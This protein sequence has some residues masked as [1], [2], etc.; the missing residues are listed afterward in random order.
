[1]S[2][3]FK[4]F[5]KEISLF[6]GALLAISIG[7]A[8]NYS[9]KNS[10][11]AILTDA[12]P[13]APSAETSAQNITK[14]LVVETP[15]EKIL[16]ETLDLPKE[17]V[18]VKKIVH[19]G[20][21][22]RLGYTSL[23]AEFKYKDLAHSGT[24]PEWL[25]GSFVVVGPGKF[26]IQSSK[27]RTWLDGFAMIHRFSFKEGR[28]SYA[29][30]FLETTYYN[31]SI[32]QGKMSD[33][34]SAGDP[35]ASYF[36]KL[37]AAMSDSKSRPVYDNTNINIIC[38]NHSWMALT[39]TPG[40]TVVDRHSLKTKGKQTFNDS[41]SPHVSCAYPYIDPKT[42]QL[43]N[44]MTTYARSKSQ[45][46]IYTVDPKKNERK[47]LTTLTTSY[48][49]YMH[50]FSV[51][52]HYIILAEFPLVVNPYD[53]AMSGKPYIEN[54]QWK[55]KQGTKFTILNRF[56]GTIADTFT[57]D[58][59]FSLNHINAFE[60]DNSIIID[61]VAHKDA[62]IVKS[63]YL[64]D[65]FKNKNHP[66]FHGTLKRISINLKNNTIQ[67][68]QLNPIPLEM[69]RINN[70]YKTKPYTY[71]YALSSATG[72]SAYDRLIKI[73]LQNNSVIEWHEDYCY[74]SEPTFVARPD[75]TA[76]DDGVILSVVLDTAT[77]H[78]F[79]LIL[80]AHTME[81]VARV[82]LS[83]HIPFSVH[84]NFFAKPA[85]LKEQFN[86]HFKS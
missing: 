28:V 35:N 2:H 8:I 45:Y 70:D 59:F 13:L 73:N 5:S 49:S 40:I 74:P 76:E 3:F 41:L 84:G 78:S 61:L 37:A 46:T 34:A 14:P 19:S 83:H 17:T 22:H 7:L 36:S 52:P 63:Y 68:T 86:E 62:S 66:V 6:I 18:P 65:I 32:A 4:R 10:S 26:E 31:D 72:S 69:P 33:A 51:T 20:A 67:T 54:F 60:Q 30:K 85:T 1:M 9:I 27:A 21:D 55:P 25:K 38:F 15:V 64:E 75:S 50:N 44:I 53:L 24:I 29:N 77:K 11:N 23:P 39:E 12:A 16:P 43:I 80:D 58:A 81:E 47:P 79:L 82:E 56:D 57:T 71:I 42:G 48:P